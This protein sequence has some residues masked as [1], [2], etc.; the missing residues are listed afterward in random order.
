MASTSASVTSAV[1][2]S[3]RKALGRIHLNLGQHLEVSRVLQVGLRP[4]RY[5]LD[6]RPRRGPELL[7]ADG[8]GKRGAHQIAHHLGAHLLAE[9]LGDDREWRL[10]GP[11]ALE[12]R[13]ARQALQ[14]LLHLLSHLRGGYGDFETPRQAAR[15]R[16]RNFHQFIPGALRDPRSRKAIQPVDLARNLVRKE[17]LELSRVSP[18]D[19]KSS[20]S[21]SSATFA[22]RARGRC[23]CAT[24]LGRA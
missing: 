18:L 20:A 12:T 9:L 4:E 3:M 15:V 6:A 13:R 5:R 19:P 16:Q 14:A 21:A 2:R 17:R 1:G 8:L 11:E 24:P 10:A 7:L 22:C 23:S